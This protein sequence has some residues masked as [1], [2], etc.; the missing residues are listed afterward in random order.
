MAVT[1]TFSIIKPDATRRNLTGGVTKMLE[2]AGLVSQKEGRL[3]LTPKGLRKI[4]SNALRDLFEEEEGYW[5]RTATEV[6]SP[7]QPTPSLRSALAAQN[8]GR[9]LLGILH[10][11][12][13]C[14]SRRRERRHYLRRWWF[15]PCRGWYCRAWR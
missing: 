2:D 15:Q 10:G 4:G 3:E 9:M 5:R 7:G 11:Y 13:A 12:L 8:P 6:T 1:R 14:F